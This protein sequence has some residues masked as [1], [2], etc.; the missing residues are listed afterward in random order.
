MTK[1][2]IKEQ[3]DLVVADSVNPDTPPPP[4]TKP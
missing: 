4:P 1:K 3:E 2:I